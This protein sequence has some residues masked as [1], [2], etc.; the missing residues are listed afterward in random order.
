MTKL[1]FVILFFVSIL[2]GSIAYAAE[3]VCDAATL[4]VVAKHLKL[5]DFYLYDFETNAGIV[6]SAAYKRTP[7]D[8]NIELVA[9]AYNLPDKNTSQK[10]VKEDPNADYELS[11][12]HI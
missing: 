10:L 11:L 3:Q 7:Q 1:S 12:I 2:F 6:V 5:K 9:I 4:D 8:K